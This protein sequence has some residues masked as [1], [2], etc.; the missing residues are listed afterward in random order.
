MCKIDLKID[1]AAA[2]MKEGNGGVGGGCALASILPS[3][4]FHEVG[5]EK[6]GAL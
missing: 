1:Y 4:L 3:L 2:W 5:K 6:C